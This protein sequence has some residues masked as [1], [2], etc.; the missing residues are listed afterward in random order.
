MHWG[1]I[2]QVKHEGDIIKNCSNSREAIMETIAMVKFTHNE[3]MNK[4]LCISHWKQSFIWTIFFSMITSK[5]SA[6]SNFLFEGKVK[7]QGLKWS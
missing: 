4:K 5:V 6:Y 1:L 3:H 2:K 7:G